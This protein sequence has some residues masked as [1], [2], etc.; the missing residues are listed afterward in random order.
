M[1]P[2]D[3][4]GNKIKRFYGQD[5][6]GHLKQ[7]W[8][9]GTGPNNTS[10]LQMAVVTPVENDP[11]RL[12]DG[13]PSG[14]YWQGTYRAFVREDIGRLVQYYFNNNDN[15]WHWQVITPDGLPQEAIS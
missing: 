15:R 8:M 6:S 9:D 7:F 10:T 13:T 14:I 2:I 5:G 3:S 12:I 11:E 1:V 4:L